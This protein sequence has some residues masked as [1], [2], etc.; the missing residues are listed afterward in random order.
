M[1]KFSYCNYMK[2]EKV[3]ITIQPSASVSLQ[4]LFVY[5]KIIETGGTQWQFTHMSVCPAQIRMKTGR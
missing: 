5:T 2:S 3:N 4:R 1:N